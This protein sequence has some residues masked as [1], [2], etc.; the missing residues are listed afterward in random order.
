[1]ER[2]VRLSPISVIIFAIALL[3]AIGRLY[4]QSPP[5]NG[6]VYVCLFM[7]N[8][9]N[10][11]RDLTS[12]V[13]QERYVQNRAA[14]VEFCRMIQRNGVAF[15]W[16]PEWL[17]LEAALKWETPELMAQTNGKNIVRFIKEDMGISVDP[18][19]HEQKGYNYADVA[20]LIDSLGVKPTTVIG[21]HVWDP[22]SPNFQEWDR[23]RQPLRGSKYPWYVW[24]GNI[25][26]GSGTPNHV[27]DPSPSG[28]WRPKDRYNY[29]VD[30]PNANVYAV[31]Q[32]ASTVEGVRQLVDLYKNGAISS[33]KILTATFS[34]GQGRLPGETKPFEDTVVKPLLEMQARGE[35]KIVTFVELIRLFEEE[36][37]GAG[38]IYNAPSGTSSVGETSNAAEYQLQA[39]PNPAT[40]STM[41]RFAVPESASVAVT[42]HDLVGQCVANLAEGRVEAGSYSIP[43]PARIAA[44]AYLLRLQT[45]AGAVTAP[46]WV[47]E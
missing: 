45:P 35:V 47:M 10:L 28:V 12:Q 34:T 25:L 13:S 5:Q 44:G 20:C 14:L 33:D 22:E 37:G 2:T 32:Y 39:I 8:E 15:N 21:G 27:N 7:H 41:V 31:G 30:D 23:F 6:V 24:P 18:H 17:F 43:L 46:L 36:Y 40:S 38:H 26:I 9:D 16:E 19:S 4:G 29:F 11:L 3:C 1:M 42:L